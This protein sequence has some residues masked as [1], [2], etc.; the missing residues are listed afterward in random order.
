LGDGPGKGR[1]AW[2][3]AGAA[4]VGEHSELP[5]RRRWGCGKD[6]SE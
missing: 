3:A 2:V 4:K 5:K 6:E 1:V